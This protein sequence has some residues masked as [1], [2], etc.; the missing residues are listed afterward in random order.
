[1]LSYTVIMKFTSV[2]EI[3]PMEKVMDQIIL[4]AIRWHVLDNQEIRSSLTN[5]IF[6][7]KVT[8]LV[9]EGRAVDVVYLDFSEAFD[10]VSHSIHLEKLAGH[11]GI[12]CNLSQFANDTK[13]SGSVDLLEGRKALQR[14]LAQAGLMGQ[15]QLHEVQQGKV[16][17]PALGSQWKRTWGCWSTEGE[18]E[19]AVCPGGQEG[20]WHPGLDQQ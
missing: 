12:Q 20:Q 11:E 19:P 17:G 3:Y 2:E 1:M 13:L 6:Y 18:H 16:P 8:H 10:T 9:D 5:L 14:G 15:G 4:C 7:D